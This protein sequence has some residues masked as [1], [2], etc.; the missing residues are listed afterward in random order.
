MLLL[1]PLMASA[2]Y[3]DDRDD[4]R[5]TGQ[6]SRYRNETGFS[7][8][9][10]I[11]SVDS[12]GHEISVKTAQSRTITVYAANADIYEGNTKRDIRILRRGDRVIVF[13]REIRYNSVEAKT[14][15]EIAQNADYDYD[16]YS[17]NTRNTRAVGEIRRIDTRNKRIKISGDSNFNTVV[18]DSETKIYS[19]SGRRLTLSQLKKGDDI[20]VAGGRIRGKIIHAV[21]IY[22]SINGSIW[23]PYK[24]GDNYDRGRDDDRYDRRQASVRITATVRNFNTRNGRIYINRVNNYSIVI[25]NSSTRIYSSSG[26]VVSLRDLDEGDSIRVVGYSTKRNELIAMEIRQQ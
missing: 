25:A 13:G 19:R 15:Y 4:Y 1:I 16:D 9:G 14:I 5:D 3:S 7:I 24:Y 22:I 23:S 18:V 21:D 6:M 2:Q 11:S 8:R 17:T 20:K 12:G 26:R 10:I